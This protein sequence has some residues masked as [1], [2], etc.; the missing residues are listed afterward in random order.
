VAAL[1]TRPEKDLSVSVEELLP[2]WRERAR[3]TG[4]GPRRIEAVLGRVPARAMCDEAAAPSPLRPD[5][6][7]TAALAQSGRADVDFSRRHAVRAWASSRPRGAPAAGVE[8]RVDTFLS[9][10]AVVDAHPGSPHVDGPGVAERSRA[11]S[12][13]VRAGILD[14][15]AH[16]REQLRLETLLRRRGM[17]LGA[18]ATRSHRRGVPLEQELG[19]GMGR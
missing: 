16:Q 11:L 5:A 12:D 18:E 10:P 9:S 13:D 8:E 3:A 14:R 19:L 7:L 17:A 15:G 6:E 4:L 2:G 1:S